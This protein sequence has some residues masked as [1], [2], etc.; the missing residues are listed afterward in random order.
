MASGGNESWRRVKYRKWQK[1]R[2]GNTKANGRKYQAYGHHRL[3]M[4]KW[5]WHGGV[6]GQW[7]KQ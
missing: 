2:N 5:L 6:T 4:K 7:R 3:K 1:R